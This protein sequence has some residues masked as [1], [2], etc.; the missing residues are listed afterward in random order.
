MNVGLFKRVGIRYEVACD[1]LGGMISGHAEFIGI[2]RSKPSPDQLAI[3]QAVD[4]QSSL[5]K[6]RD[7][8]DPRDAAAIEQV[9]E[10]FAENTRACA[11][12][13]IP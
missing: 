11:W 12:P 7:D 6:F 9:I 3:S 10:E 2:E 8:L 13:I 4:A 1:I 5:R